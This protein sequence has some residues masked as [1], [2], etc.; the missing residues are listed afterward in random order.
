MSRL[1]NDAK[2]NIL[3]KFHKSEK[4]LRK[5]SNPAPWKESS[6]RDPKV[7]E[8]TKNTIKKIPPPLASAENLLEKKLTPYATNA[9]IITCDPNG[10]KVARSY[11]IPANTAQGKRESNPSRSVQ[12]RTSIRTT[13]GSQAEPD[14]AGTELACKTVAQKIIMEY[15][16]NFFICY[17]IPLTT[18]TASESETSAGEATTA[19]WKRWSSEGRTSWTVPMNNPLGTSLPI[20]DVTISS[21]TETES[22]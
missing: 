5:K 6:Q 8:M 2:K 14:N 20:P 22:V 1:Q 12:A 4:S 9:N 18:K 7:E 19:C 15:M 10:E 11:R 16:E 17:F 13:S 3:E 21:P